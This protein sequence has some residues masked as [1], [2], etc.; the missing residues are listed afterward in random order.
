MQIYVKSAEK[1]HSLHHL[2]HVYA[3]C[4]TP[5]TR[6]E[7]GDQFVTQEKDFRDGLH[8]R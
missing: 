4:F 5:Q 6:V 3:S 7:T 1:K 8:F 2:Q